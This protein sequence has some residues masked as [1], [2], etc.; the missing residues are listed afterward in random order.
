MAKIDAF[1]NLMM[2][3]K[4]PDLQLASGNNP[5][6]RISGELRRVDYPPLQSDELK[7]MLY[8][9]APDVKIKVYEETGDVDF[10][11]RNFDPACI[12]PFEKQQMSEE[13]ALAHCSKRGNCSRGLDNVKKKRGEVSGPVERLSMQDGQGAP[14]RKPR[15]S[16]PGVGDGLK[17]K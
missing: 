10:G 13:S 8:E 1:F 7:E 14:R 15:S 17:L 6:L 11:W 9:I 3:Q 4:A 16:S 5:M 2:Q 12:E